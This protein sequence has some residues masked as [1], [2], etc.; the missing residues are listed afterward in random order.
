MT[1]NKNVMFVLKYLRFCSF[2]A[3][4]LWLGCF[5]SSPLLAEVRFEVDKLKPGQSLTLKYRVRVKSSDSIPL[6][7]RVVSSQGTVTHDGATEIFYTSDPES[8]LVG[9]STDTPLVF[10]DSDGDGIYDDLDGCPFAEIKTSP[11][12]CGCNVLDTDV[13]KNGVADCLLN[14]DL[15]DLLSRAD[16]LVR[17]LKPNKKLRKKKQRKRQRLNK[18]ELRSLR[19]FI[20][21]IFNASATE[22]SVTSADVKLPKLYKKL[23][24]QMRKTLRT[25]SKKFNKFKKQTRKSLRRLDDVLL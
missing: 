2:S 3:L 17:K 5:Y 18:K 7:T 23:N 10:V 14:L 21:D 4:F 13:N 22:L 25:G 16:V 15:K 8:S 6:S 1:A 11:G 12:S 20:L 9:A 24:I 19:K